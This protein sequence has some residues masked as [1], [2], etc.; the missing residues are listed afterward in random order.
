MKAT[1]AILI[2][3]AVLFMAVPVAQAVVVW[4]DP[5]LNW[6]FI[7]MTTVPVNDLEIILDNP[8]FTLNAG[9]PNQ[10][11]SVPFT[12]IVKTTGDFDGDL[13][14]DTKITF[15]GA[16]INPGQTAHGGLYMLGSGMVLDAYWT[17]NGVKVGASTAIT[18]E[19]TR[20]VG[21]PQ[22]FMELSIAPGFFEDPLNAGHEAAWT[23]IRTFVNI[24]ADLLDLPD[25]NTSLDLSTLAAFEVTPRLGGPAG[26]IINT[27]D[28]IVAPSDSSFVDIFLADIDPAFS[29]ENYEA[30]LVAT[31]M[32]Q[33][34]VIG[35]FWNLNPQSPEPATM[36]LMGVGGAALLR[37]RRR[38]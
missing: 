7:N 22:V 1:R 29:N 27:S 37:R 10:A 32:N 6:D 14:Q 20:I 15:S 38:K 3:G 12:S 28:V 25:L 17:W 5:Y 2:I 18:Y 26:P 33:P 30:L 31:V 4:H 23:E 11:W 19:Q 24:P 9:N 34:T 13:D 21:D 8:N 36:F 16:V 35:Q